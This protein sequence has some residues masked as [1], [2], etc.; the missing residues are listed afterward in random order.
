MQ[1][2]RAKAVK[3]RQGA[4]EGDLEYGAAWQVSDGGWA[5]WGSGPAKVRRP[6]QVAVGGLYQAGVQVTTVGVQCCQHTPGRHLE[7]CVTAGGRPIE[8]AVGG[9]HYPAVRV[10][11]VSAY[12]D[13]RAKFVAAVADLTPEHPTT[14][15]SYRVLRPDGA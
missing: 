9:L 3:R 11:P 4:F 14:R 6:V 8:V 12:P 5:I 15:I 13:D 2:L 10:I 7:D 1:G